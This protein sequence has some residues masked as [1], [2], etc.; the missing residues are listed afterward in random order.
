MKI[1]KTK[2]HV[3]RHVITINEDQYGG[4]ED[5]WQEQRLVKEYFIFDFKVWSRVLDT[6]RIP[7][8]VWIGLATLG[9]SYGWQSKFTPFDRQGYK[10]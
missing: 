2:L 5:Q 4:C 1:F 10:T 8:Y 7:S 6:E 9:E 3:T